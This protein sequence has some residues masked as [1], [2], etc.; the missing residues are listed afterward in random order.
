MNLGECNFQKIHIKKEIKI[1]SDMG[2]KDAA[3]LWGASQDRVRA[4]CK[5]TDD[6]QITQDKK[7][8]PYHNSEGLSEPLGKTE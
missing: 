7:G 8:C 3:E 2:T 6:E 1:M 4:W 5:R